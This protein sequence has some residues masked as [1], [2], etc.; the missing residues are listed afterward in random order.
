MLDKVGIDNFK[1]E[2]GE[3]LDTAGGQ[4]VMLPMLELS[5]QRSRYISDVLYVYNVANTSRDGATMHYKYDDSIIIFASGVSNSKETREEEFQREENLLKS[6]DKEKMLVYFGTCSVNDPT[7][8]NSPYVRHKMVMEYII[9][10]N[11]KKNIVFRLPIVVGRT[12]NHK[13]FFNYFK[14]KINNESEIQVDLLSSRYLIDVD[15]LSEILTKIIEQYRAKDEIGQLKMNIAFD[16]K[17]MVQDIVDMM[18]KILNKKS[19]ITTTCTGCDYEF[20]KKEFSDFL[21]SISYKTPEDYT[22]NLLKKYLS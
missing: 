18:M 10:Y 11:F 3:W 20:D 16:N 7:V 1:R 5:G 2:D 13:T 4:A 17:T 14:E 22:Y 9:K 8:Q 12:N 6:L 19:H 21:S 15:D